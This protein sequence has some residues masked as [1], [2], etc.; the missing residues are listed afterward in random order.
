MEFLV[1]IAMSPFV[2]ISD[3]LIT[4]AE[5]STRSSPY[6]LLSE[7]VLPERVICESLALTPDALFALTMLPSNSS[8]DLSR[9]I[10]SLG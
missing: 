7:T 8:D 9:V 2:L 3:L 4:T 10:P 5:L 1:L 6:L